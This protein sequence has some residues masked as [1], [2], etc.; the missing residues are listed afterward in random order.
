[1]DMN[2]RFTMLLRRLMA[3]AATAAVLAIVGISAVLAGLPW[4]FASLGPSVAIQTATPRHHSARIKAVLLGHGFAL[5]SALGIVYLTGAAGVPALSHGHALSLVRVAAAALAV[6]TGM[7]LELAVDALHPPS[8]ST[9]LLVALGIL[10]PTPRTVATIVCG[11]M[12]VGVL[13]EAMRR[14]MLRAQ[15]VTPRNQH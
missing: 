2:D 10:P 12:L 11:V 3:P 7:T 13:G 14:L 6:G 15:S 1:M 8:A 9:A 4:L 5:G